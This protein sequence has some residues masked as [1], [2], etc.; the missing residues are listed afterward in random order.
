MTP[1]LALIIGGLGFW[2]GLFAVSLITTGGLKYD[3]DKW[4]AEDNPNEIARNLLK[5]EF[6]QE[7]I[8]STIFKTIG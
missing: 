3:N 8:I 6:N 7:K 2:I 1:R 4:L 5:N